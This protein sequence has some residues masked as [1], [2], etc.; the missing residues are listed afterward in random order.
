MMVSET[1]DVLFE[2]DKVSTN[3]EYLGGMAISDIAAGVDLFQPTIG[4]SGSTILTLEG[5]KE[6][7]LIWR[8]NVYLQKTPASMQISS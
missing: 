6:Y 1:T 7:G 5:G 3:A 8:M 2:W 4:T